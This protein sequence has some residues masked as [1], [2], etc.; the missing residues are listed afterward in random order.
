MKRTITTIAGLGAAVLVAALTCGTASAA[1]NTPAVTTTS[2]SASADATRETRSGTHVVGGGIWT[3]G[4]GAGAVTSVYDNHRFVHSTAVKSSG[5]TK[6]SG[7][8]AKGKL[9]V[10]IRPSARSGNQAFWNIY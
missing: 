6:S 10:A 8:V 3:Y 7:R 5:A 1:P 9:A 4:V 2:G